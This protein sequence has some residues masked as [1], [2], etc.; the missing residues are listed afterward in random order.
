MNAEF[1]H[2]FANRVRGRLGLRQHLLPHE[3]DDRTIYANNAAANADFCDNTVVTYVT[4]RN[5]ALRPSGRGNSRFCGAV[6]PTHC[7]TLLLGELHF[8]TYFLCRSKYTWYS[9]VPLFLFEQFTRFANAY[10]LMVRLAP[11]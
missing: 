7:S 10:F 11:V 5:C 4:P 6:L 1:W 9:F 3:Q 8:E 2:Q